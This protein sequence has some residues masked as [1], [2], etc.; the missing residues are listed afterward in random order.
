M[1]EDKD[2]QAIASLLEKQDAKLDA[3]LEKQNAKIDD[4]LKQQKRDIMNEVKALIENDVTPKFNLLADG[5][6]N[7]D[8]K[9][10]TRSEMETVKEELAF[11]KSILRTHS[12]QINELKKAQ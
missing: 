11:I 6:A 10:V 1:L 5:L 2:L 3:T 4:A 8:A 12:D 9:L 7:I